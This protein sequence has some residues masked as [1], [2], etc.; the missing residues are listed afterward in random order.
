MSLNL[1]D[2]VK[3]QVT[4]SLV[5]QATSYLGESESS[6]GKALGG[7]M[8]ALLGSAVEKAS[9]PTGAQGL[10][11][12]I[13]GLDLDSLGNIAGL[14]GGGDE[15]VNGLLNSGGG[16]VDSLLGSKSSGVIDMISKFAGL[17]N[18]S[19]STLFKMAAP[20]LMGVIGRQIKGKGLSALTDLLMGQKI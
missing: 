19:T 20:L 1:L 6:I 8:P 12:M 10:M 15:K 4:D 17:K 3:S 13:G 11:D 14:F 9:K 2:L 5:K 7:I 18:D 16:L